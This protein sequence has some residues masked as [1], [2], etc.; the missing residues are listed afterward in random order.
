M[1]GKEDRDEKQAEMWHS[2]WLHWTWDGDNNK[3]TP[4][5]FKTTA[6]STHAL[7]GVTPAMTRKKNAC[8]QKR[9]STY[10]L[11]TKTHVFYTASAVKPTKKGRQRRSSS[12]W[13]WRI[14]LPHHQDQTPYPVVFQDA[15]QEEERDDTME[16]REVI[17]S[18]EVERKT[19]GMKMEQQKQQKASEIIYGINP[20]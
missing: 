16:S 8:G 10:I 1:Y 15:L 18:G 19:Q 7:H 6:I 3:Q 13:W 20:K 11:Q 12:M 9:L 5:L 17:V 14:C 4:S 2:N